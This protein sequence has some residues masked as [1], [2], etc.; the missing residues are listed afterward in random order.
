MRTSG[1]LLMLVGGLTM[2]C[3]KRVPV[4]AN[5]TPGTPRV[6]WVLMY[7]DRDNADA[8][9]ACESD[10]AEACVLP[11]T[12]QNAPVFSN[13]HI[14]YHGAGG[15]TRYEGTVKIGYL[16]GTG[17]PHTARTNVTV[18]KN[19]S[20]TNQSVTGIVTSTPG[21]YDVTFSLTAADA[22]G[23]SVPIREALR[24][25]VRPPAATGDF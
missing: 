18:K 1:L 20:I 25:T 5:S 17:E 3:A 23:H 11:A 9:F 14:Y 7:G 22:S 10:K 12:Q 4:P 8:Q 2:A 21:V 15:E 16:Q 6:T 24:V 13:I 19:E